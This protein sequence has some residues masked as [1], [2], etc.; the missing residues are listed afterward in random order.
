MTEGTRLWLYLE[1]LAMGGVVE[2]LF[3]AFD[4]Y[5]RE[6]G[7]LAMGGQ[8]IDASIVAAPK[9]RSSREENEAI[10]AAHP[11][12]EW[13][14]GRSSYGYRNHVSIDCRHK[15][16]RR[17]MVID[18]ARHDSQELDGL[19][20]SDNTS[21]E[22]W[23]DSAYRSAEIEQ[24]L[25]E[26]SF[27]SRIHRRAARNRPLPPCKSQGNTTRS[28]VQAC[29]EHVFGHQVTAMGCKIVRT[30]GQVRTSPT[31]CAASDIW[32]RMAAAPA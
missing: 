5:L 18:V 13:K 14:H 10:K 7:Y 3:D 1:A 21:A 23:G 8:L 24:R 12:P 9:L 11:P 17:Y 6:Q 2:Q 27:K 15:L 28:R 29:V 30:I 25:A 20:D 22:V 31:T 16:V 4:G 32:I 26:R 19:L